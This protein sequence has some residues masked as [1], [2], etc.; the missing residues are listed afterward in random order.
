MVAS[1]GETCSGSF[2][3]PTATVLRSRSRLNPAC[4]SAACVK[5]CV[6]HAPTG[7]RT[8]TA[9]GQWGCC[10]E[11]GGA[12]IF[13]ERVVEGGLGDPRLG[14]ARGAAQHARNTRGEGGKDRE[15]PRARDAVVDITTVLGGRGREAQDQVL[16]LRGE[17][18][19]AHGG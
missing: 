16:V 15:R 18:G 6:L 10:K 1:R 14:E 13:L 9:R 2:F 8:R 11:A 4:E 5:T 12:D 3:F 17:V 19:E 7:P